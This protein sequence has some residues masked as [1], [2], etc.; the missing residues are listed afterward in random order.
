MNDLNA[1]GVAKA[2]SK[3]I[4]EDI[5]EWCI[6]TYDG[7][8]RTHLGA[9]LIG[10]EC[11]R[12]LWY[13]FRWVKH[14]KMEKEGNTPAENVANAG[15]LYRLFNRGHREEDRFIEWLEGIGVQVWAD[16]L[17]N[18]K[19]FYC[20]EDNSYR[21]LSNNQM[22][23]M[24]EIRDAKSQLEID[25]TDSKLHIKRAKADGLE[26]PQYRISAVSG[27]FGGSLDGV[28]KL[29][30][31]FGINEPVLLEF[32]TIGAKYHKKLVKNGMIVEK[33]QHFAQT[34]TYGL[35]YSLNYCLYM[36][37]CKDTDKIHLELVKLNHDL[38]E[39]MKLKAEQIIRSIVAPPALSLDPTFFKC[40]FC[41]F[42]DICH[43]GGVCEKN[44]R[45]CK[46]AMPAEN[47]E[48]V[49]TLRDETIPKDFIPLACN[50]YIAIT[51]NVQ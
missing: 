23:E 11:K 35:E 10:D 39:E 15:R 24:E 38:G 17:Q 21:L 28:A 29:P 22:L 18:H 32:K 36:S 45:S 40:K 8:H 46:H 3:R 1:P 47:A 41:N 19:L 26:F 25:V 37:I 16:D 48:W 49:C 50:D 14:D 5:D 31:R 27:H 30:E 51:N 6:T 12:K 33:L 42:N 7:G 13:V 34:S 20:E 43:S 44:C 2:V 9:S 4:L